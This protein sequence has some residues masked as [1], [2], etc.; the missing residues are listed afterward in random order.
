MI[1]MMAES[2]RYLYVF[3]HPDDESFGPALAIS[4]Q[5]REGHEVHLLTL[6]KGGAT[7]QRHELGLTVAEMGE[8][9]AREMECVRE[10]LDLSSFELH[11]L[12][13]GALAN[14]D[15]IEI[16][17]I[18]EDSIRKVRP[19]V[20]VTYAVHGV[21]GFP[22]HLVTHAVVKRVFSAIRR[23]NAAPELARLALFTVLPSDQP[24]TKFELKTTDP[25]E[26][27]ALISVGEDDL[28]SAR[29]SLACYVTYRSVIDEARPLDRVGMNVPFELFGER[30]DP[31]LDALHDSLS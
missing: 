19:H 16:E 22:D 12:P 27:G 20:L 10:V 29:Q 30:F 7:K 9:R 3:P 6:T 25:S 24:D 18:V 13:D 17:Q 2:F 4:K 15:P 28:E 8:V 23:E 11:D 1:S 14:H 31:P 26:I 5:R 21:S